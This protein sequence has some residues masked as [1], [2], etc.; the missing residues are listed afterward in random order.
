MCPKTV[1]WQTDI[2]RR[3]AK[4]VLNSKFAAQWLSSS[5]Y[6]TNPLLLK[7]SLTSAIQLIPS[8]V[9]PVKEGKLK[10]GISVAEMQQLVVRGLAAWEFPG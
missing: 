3:Y 6:L 1:P 4:V 5:R 8:T 10:S 2:H 9:W 7:A